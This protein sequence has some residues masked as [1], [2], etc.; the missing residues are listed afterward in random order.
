MQIVSACNCLLCCAMLCY[1]WLVRPVASVVLFLG[2]LEWA[3]AGCYVS[4]QQPCFQCR[5]QT[6]ISVLDD[7][8]ILCSLSACAGLGCCLLPP[9]NCKLPGVEA[10]P[11]HSP[12]PAASTDPPIQ[13]V[14]LSTHHTCFAAPPPL[15]RT[16]CVVMSPHPDHTIHALPCRRVLVLLCSVIVLQPLM[17][18]PS[19]LA[20]RL[21]A[22][23]LS[24][25][26]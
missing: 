7:V 5:G 18:Y 13:P 15:C 25:C 1:E 2:Q 23:S 14:G 11:T 21:M 22:A 9:S 8:A 3:G 24:W 6:N 16:T 17:W 19:C 20:L 10:H 4:S 26:Q 12:S